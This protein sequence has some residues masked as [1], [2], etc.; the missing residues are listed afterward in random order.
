[1]RL[2][3]SCAARSCSR[4]S[5]R[6]LLAAQ[7]LAVQ[8]LRAGEV[9][10]RSRLRAEPL[11]RLAVERLGSLALAQQRARAGL[12]PE[13][14]VR[15]GGARPLLEPPQRRGGDVG[16][17]GP[18]GRLDQ[19]GER[20]AE[21]AQVARTRTRAGRRP[22]RPRSGR[23]RCAA[24]PAR[25]RP[26]RSPALRRARSRP[27]WG[28]DQLR[29]LGPVAAPGGEQRATCT[30]SGALPVAALIASASSISAAA[31]ANSPGVD[32]HAGAVVSAIGSTRE[33][34][35]LARQPAPRAGEPVPRLVVPQLGRSVRR[36]GARQP[37]PAQVVLGGVRAPRQNASQRRLSGGAPA[38]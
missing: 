25:T 19:L 6:R 12:A 11:D 9:D 15:A 29:G 7:P 28:L 13:R 36:D 27:R 32:V 10:A 34:A 38:A 24:P 4:A 18:R 22:A 20:P 14:P 17:A 35:G 16:R 23:G 26:G 1:M 30:R 2:N 21:E 8:Q 33:R 31:A 5:T 37:Q 3:I